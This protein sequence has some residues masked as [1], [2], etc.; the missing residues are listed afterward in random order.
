[1]VRV[2][3]CKIVRIVVVGLSAFC[4]AS[5]GSRQNLESIN[6]RLL[7]VEAAIDP[8]GREPQT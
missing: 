2:A 7:T 6:H 5:C 4:R 1:M 3:S 8:W